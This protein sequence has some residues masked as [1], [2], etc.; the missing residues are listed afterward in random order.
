M[1][2]SPSFAVAFLREVLGG[3]LNVI[4]LV[5][6]FAGG[7]VVTVFGVPSLAV[8]GS[9]AYAEFQITPRIRL[10]N[11]V[12]RVGLLLLVAGF[13]CQLIPAVVPRTTRPVTASLIDVWTAASAFVSAVFWAASAV[14]R[15]KFGF[16]NDAALTKAFAWSGRLNAVAATFAALAAALQAAKPFLLP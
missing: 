1:I 4:G 5:L 3:N 10:Y 11:R 12:S 6:G 13:A 7:V 2:A 16:D 8:L 9:G 14:V 15:V